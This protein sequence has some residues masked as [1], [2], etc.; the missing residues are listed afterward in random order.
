MEIKV[1]VGSACYVKGSHEVIETL[2]ELIKAYGLE[3]QV[4]LKA[5]FCLGHCTDAVSIQIGDVIYGVPKEEVTTFFK[6][7]V[8]RR[9][10]S[11]K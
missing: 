5:A 8:Y 4:V 9:I 7:Q 1:C 3:K 11:C 2:Q 6:E 10:Q